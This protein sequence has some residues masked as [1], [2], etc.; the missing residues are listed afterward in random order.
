MAEENDNDDVVPQPKPYPK[1]L[2]DEPEKK[3][4]AHQVRDYLWG[5]G[6]IDYSIV[7]SH[8]KRDLVS[9]FVRFEISDL[10]PQYFWRVRILADLYHLTE[11]LNYFQQMLDRR[12][13][14]PVDLD[15]SIANTIILNEIGD[16]G[17]K[18][19]AVQYYEYL[20]SHQFANQKF[21]ELIKCLASLGEIAKPNSLRSR[22]DSEIKALASREASDPEADIE[23]RE[24]E[25]IVGNEFFF[26]EESN[27]SRTRILGIADVRQRLQALIE[28]YLQLSEDG[29]GEFFD[30]WVQQQLRR[31]S[32]AEGDKLVIDAFRATAKDASKLARGDKNYCLVRCYNA[33]EYFRGELNEDEK[34]FMKKKGD[35]QVDPLRFMPLPKHI[36]PLGDADEEEEE[37]DEGEGEKD[38]ADAEK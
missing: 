6:P 8:M 24:V 1:E 17:Q 37:E 33:I 5:K 19:Q 26:I 27:N 38:E 14:K 16:E 34:A 2:V 23:R 15:K 21:R 9:Q 4:V 25:D 3:E 30:L 28:A 13:Q 18:E 12:E 35:I 29:G 36:D 20:T 11:L 31:I 32:E 7:T 10:P 22:M